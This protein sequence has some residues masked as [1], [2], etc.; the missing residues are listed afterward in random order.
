MPKLTLTA[1]LKL[2]GLSP[3]TITAFE[4]TITNYTDALNYV[5]QFVA[6]NK[7]YRASVIQVHHHVYRYVKDTFNLNAQMAC[8][9][10][11]VVMAKYKSLISNKRLFKNKKESVINIPV[12]KPKEVGYVRDR[13]YRFLKTGQIALATSDGI[14]HVDYYS[15][16]YEHLFTEGWLYGEAK[17]KRKNGA[18]YLYMSF[19]KEVPDGTSYDNIV[20]IDVGLNFIATSYNGK[21]TQF[22]SG[23]RVKEYRAHYKELRRQLQSKGTK[24][25]KRRL[26]AINA[27][28]N[29]FIND[30]NHCVSKALVRNN[31]KSL[32]VVEDLGNIR[33]ALTK[34]KKRDRYYMVSWAYSDLI[35]K[36]SYKAEKAGSR[37]VKVDPKYTSQT[38]PHCGYRDKGN[39]NRKEHL[40]SCKQCGYR[41]ND[42]RI[43]AMNL[44]SKGLN[45]LSK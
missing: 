28:E 33:P 13:N 4:N 20:G 45:S 29:R 7:L 31:P 35:N 34:V 22:Y 16:G 6:D 30:V 21:K 43:G 40:F 2:R 24:S 15:K 14:K 23:K 5:S 12:F 26:K 9:V 39:R 19:S 42:D 37:V 41:S 36:L 44:Y 27:R 17:L 3:S 38:C 1:K 32:F 10:P 8:S 18:Y 25:A 11:R